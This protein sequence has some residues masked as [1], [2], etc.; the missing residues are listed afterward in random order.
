MR[1]SKQQKPRS[2]YFGVRLLHSFLG[3]LVEDFQF[4]CLNEISQFLL[5]AL[6]LLLKAF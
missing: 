1:K 3:F 5:D 6:A 2:K 4:N